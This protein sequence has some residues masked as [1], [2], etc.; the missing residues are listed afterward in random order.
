MEP[1]D[2]VESSNE[3]HAGA[4]GFRLALRGAAGN[5]GAVGAKVMLSLSDGRSILAE[6]GAAA[7]FFA[8]PNDNLPARLKIR[9]PDGRVSEQTFAT[10]PARLLTITAP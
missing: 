3:G 9:W 6:Q 7:L 10:P 8:Y 2:A 4:R 1:G 5:P